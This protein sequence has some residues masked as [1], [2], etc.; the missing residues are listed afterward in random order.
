MR[1]SSQQIFQVRFGFLSLGAT[2][3]L[4]AV[5]QSL[6]ARGGESPGPNPERPPA[7]APAPLQRLL[8]PQE[9]EPRSNAPTQNP[10]SLSAPPR[11]AGALRRD[12]STPPVWPRNSP[13]RRHLRRVRRTARSKYHAGLAQCAARRQHTLQITLGGPAIGLNARRHRETQVSARCRSA[14]LRQQFAQAV[15]SFRHV[16]VERQSL[17]ESP[18]SSAERPS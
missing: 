5:S 18:G 12:A 14:G 9:S 11:S 1:N 16:R 3:Q 17:V 8:G 2:G 10:D 7:D 6:P 13:E 15:V 4:T